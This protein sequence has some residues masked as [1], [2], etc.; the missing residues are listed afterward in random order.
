[1]AA[2]LYSVYSLI[3]HL[4]LFT[5]VS[6]QLLVATILSHRYNSCTGSGET[7][8]SVLQCT[9]IIFTL[10][11]VCSFQR[12]WP[13]SH[14]ASYYSV[15]KTTLALWSLCNMGEEVAES[16]ISPAL[17]S[18]SGAPMS[19]SLCSAA[20][21]GRSSVVLGPTWRARPLRPC[22][23]PSR[24]GALWWRSEA[25]TQW[26]S[27]SIWAAAGQAGCSLRGACISCYWACWTATGTLTFL[28]RAQLLA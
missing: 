18:P 19:P 4:F 9:L 13:C 28:R 21:E 6:P 5:P 8:I 16:H 11:S 1:M 27:I 15:I 25:Q 23:P 2:A 10:Q 3:R 26:A 12:A 17:F 20:V 22:L 7:T 24:K 14:S